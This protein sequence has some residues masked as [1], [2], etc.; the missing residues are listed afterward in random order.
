MGGGI[1]GRRVHSG[2]VMIAPTNRRSHTGDQNSERNLLMRI[3]LQGPMVP[4]RSFLTR[5]A[6]LNVLV[7]RAGPIVG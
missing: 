3:C 6:G 4:C 2:D 5:S 1:G 7:A